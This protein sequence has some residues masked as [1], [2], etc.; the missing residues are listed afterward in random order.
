MIMPTKI[1]KPVDC[2]FSISSAVLKIIKNKKL[3]VDDLLEEVNLHY[4]K[5]ITID[6]L[7]LCL[8]FLYLIDKIEEDNEIITLKIN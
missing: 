5:K 3:S 4:Y 1:I 2:L 7:L 8:N 6:K